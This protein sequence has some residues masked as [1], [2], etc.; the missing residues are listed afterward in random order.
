MDNGLYSRC[1][2]CGYVPP[3]PMPA[4]AACAA[5]GIYFYKWAQRSSG[6]TEA[7]EG[8]QFFAEESH[9]FS[10]LQPLE[11]LDPLS[12]YGRCGALAL[13]VLWSWFLIGYD[14]R[15]AE[16]NGSFM[17]NILL[18]I[19]E[20]G[21]VLFMPF[22]EFM[23]ILGGSLFQLMLPFGIGVAFWWKNHD[24][25]G[26]AIGAWWCSASLIDLSPYIYDALHPQLILIGGHTGEDGPHDWIY[27]LNA[28][29]Q[30][31]HAQGIGAFVHGCG[32]VFMVATLIW[33]AVV[34][35]RQKALV[36][37]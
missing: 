15:D 17:H 24:N 16:I 33:A 23:A 18:P 14:Y 1:P 13:L 27:L 22:G 21:H 36:Q 5:C 12:F 30:F 7:R 20:A 4:T 9:E 6:A 34:L 35:S 19:H 32:A 31:S 37:D 3:Q 2:K 29:G 28:V 11:K 26:A 25:F 10:L 8:E